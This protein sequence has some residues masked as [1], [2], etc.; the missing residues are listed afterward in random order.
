MSII[1]QADS[2]PKYSHKY[3]SGEELKHDS[4]IMLKVA[5]CQKCS[6]I[7]LSEDFPEDEYVSDYQRNISFSKLAQEHID[8][9]ADKMVLEHGAK[10]FIEIGCGNGLF[11]GA[12]AKRGANVVGFEPSVAACKT[13]KASGF[14]VENR[15]FGKDAPKEFCGYDSFALRFVLEHVPAPL[16]ILREMASRCN[17]GAV[18]LIEVPNAEN[19]VLNKKWF[20]FF[21]EHTIYFTP[22]TLLSAINL[23]GFQLVELHT[24]M[25]DEFLTVI[26][27]KSPSVNYDWKQE[28]MKKQLLSLIEP[29]KKTW[30]WGASGAGITLLCETGI[31]SQQVEFIV[32]SDKNKWGLYASGSQIKIVPPSEIS[33][34]PPDAILILSSAYEQEI[35]NALRAQGFA[36][37]IGTI[38]PYPKWLEGK[39]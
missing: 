5:I 35:V 22:Q 12:M 7:Q 37:K 24:T 39:T 19:Q 32:D 13:A 17:D 26:V 4:K 14:K 1:F 21:R 15:F 6:L 36:G 38:F 16:D 2:C 18:G 27:K 8:K 30:V 23:S 3:L 29:G 31:K 10:N 34:S 20:E 25:R 9:F 11:L 33:V 28:E